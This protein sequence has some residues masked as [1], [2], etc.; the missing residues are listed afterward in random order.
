MLKDG[1]KLD[2]HQNLAIT[3][4]MRQLRIFLAGAVMRNC[5]L[6]QMLSN[7]VWLW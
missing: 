2:P 4:Q 3:E 1:K 7:E 6:V 5:R